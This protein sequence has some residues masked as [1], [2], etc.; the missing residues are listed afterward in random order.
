VQ[1]DEK[2][3]FFPLS[4]QEKRT[5]FPNEEIKMLKSTV[6]HRV[7]AH[8]ELGDVNQTGLNATNEGIHFVQH[9]TRLLWQ[10]FQV[11]FPKIF[12]CQL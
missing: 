9:E 6:A 11:G 8:N 2:S 7:I 3:T 4:F 5:F 1:E 10:S 12:P